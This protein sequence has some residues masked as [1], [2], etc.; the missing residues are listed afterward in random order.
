MGKSPCVIIL[1]AL[2]YGARDEA[3]VAQKSAM[4]LA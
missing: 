1:L 2:Q 3:S 4:M